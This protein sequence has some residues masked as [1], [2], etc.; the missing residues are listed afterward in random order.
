M[1]CDS[2]VV[3]FCES[4]PRQGFPRC[5][6]GP[7]IESADA[8]RAAL[9]CQPEV[10]ELKR[11]YL[12]SQTPIDNTFKATKFVS[13][14]AWLQH[15]PP[16]LPNSIG[17]SH[18]IVSKHNGIAIDNANSTANGAGVVL[19]GLNY[20]RPQVWNLTPNVDGS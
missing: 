5:V 16:T 14:V 7:Q 3:L 15:T 2:K 9:G 20:G 1:D 12:P 17:G 10:P 4:V 6:H 18:V 19:W 8:R 13:A 11:K